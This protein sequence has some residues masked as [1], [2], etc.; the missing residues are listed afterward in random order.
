MT[1]QVD[2][3][4]RKVK[5]KRFLLFDMNICFDPVIPPL[6]FDQQIYS[7]MYIQKKS[8]IETSFVVAKDWKQSKYSLIYIHNDMLLS[9]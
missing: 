7:C 4:S 5:S 8:F 1:V 2:T 9:N 6:A 3:L